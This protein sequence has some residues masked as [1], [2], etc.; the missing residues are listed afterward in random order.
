M[1]NEIKNVRSNI[2]APLPWTRMIATI[3]I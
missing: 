1:E 2:I 3:P